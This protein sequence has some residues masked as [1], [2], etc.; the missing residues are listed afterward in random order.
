MMV[1]FQLRHSP[2]TIV[3]NKNGGG[4]SQETVDN[5]KGMGAT[6]EVTAFNYDGT[7]TG[8]FNYEY[9]DWRDDDNGV[10][11]AITPWIPASFT[12]TL[13]LKTIYNI[14]QWNHLD[15]TNAI[16]SD[17]NFGTGP[18]GVNVVASR[19]D[20]EDERSIVL[21]IDPTKQNVKYDEGKYDNLGLVFPNGAMIET[22]SN[23]DV[24]KVSS[25]GKTLSN[26]P[27]WVNPYP[28]SSNYN[29][30]SAETPEGILWRFTPATT[31]PG[32]P[33]MNTNG[34]RGYKF[35]SWSLTKITP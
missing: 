34:I 8:T 17:P 16:C 18:N 33:S 20:P 31:I 30:W 14:E 6:S 28:K 29:S 15:V 26:N 4:I 35:G 23:G 13:T 27:D 32:Q 1:Y 19:N 12:L 7:Y 2:Q 9:Q 22:D 21:P 5:N 3:D 10:S 25:D 11:K 24:I